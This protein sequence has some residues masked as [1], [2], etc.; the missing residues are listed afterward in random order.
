MPI[1]QKEQ[2]KPCEITLEIEVGAEE[3]KKAFDRAYKE[4]GRHA[5][6]AGFRK[7]RA[8][9]SILENVLDKERIE[10]HAAEIMAEPAYAEALKEAEVEPYGAASYEVIHIAD[11]EPFKFRATVPTAPTVELGKYTELKAKRLPKQVSESDVE[12]RI[13]ELRQSAATVESVEGRPVEKGDMVIVAIAQDDSDPRD[14]VLEVGNNLESVD[15]GLV[16]MNA[17]ETKTID[18]VYP[19][20]YGDKSV[21]GQQLQIVVTLNDIKRRNIPELTDE[22][23]KTLKLTNGDED[24]ETVEA[25]TNYVR[26][27]L[28]K[29]FSDLADKEVETGLVDQVVEGSTICFHDSVLENEVGHRLQDLVKDLQSRKMTLEDYF[30]TTG[31]S[32]SDIQENIS[33]SA[34]RDIKISLVLEEIAK[35]ESIEV[36]DEDIEAE[37]TKMAEETGYP[38][39]SI[40]AFVD[41][42]DGRQV[43]SDK[44]AR[45]KVLEFLVNASNIK[46]VGR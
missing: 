22:F 34:E 20:D 19:E 2:N 8:P 45:R 7:G 4:A 14:T 31:K 15:S 32:F 18:V 6:I 25:L 42:T 33:K 9:R 3:V 30:R 21:A 1:I 29:A 35:K 10:G 37:I 26:E 13:N 24:V 5:E 11:A 17:G 43:I 39:E 38:R 23:V 12:A 36:A 16:G 44:I 40:M 46:N 41:K 27:S 28:E